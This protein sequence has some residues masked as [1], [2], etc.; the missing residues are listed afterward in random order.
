[1]CAKKFFNGGNWKDNAVLSWSNSESNIYNYIE[2]YFYSANLIAASLLR[3]DFISETYRDCR[4]TNGNII[5]DIT[6]DECV[7]PM[8]FLYRH[9]IEISLKQLLKKLYKFSS[10]ENTKEDIHSLESIADRIINEIIEVSQSI[11]GDYKKHLLSFIKSFI[12]IKKI[13]KEIN[14]FDASSIGCRYPI[15][16]DEQILMVNQEP[17]NVSLFMNKMLKIRQIFNWGDNLLDD[18]LKL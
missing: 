11:K 5:F 3:E 15:G 9:Y 6:K 14:D 4:D 2:G 10:K 16:K 8:I 13:C 12:S 18:M 7:F 17:L 1:M